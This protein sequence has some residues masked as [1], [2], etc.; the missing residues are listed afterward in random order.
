MK[1]EKFT[2]LTVGYYKLVDKEGWL[3]NDSRN[4]DLYER[5][6][7][8][9]MV[10]IEEVVDDWCWYEGRVGSDGDDYIIWADE[11]MYFEKV[12]TEPRVRSN[13]VDATYSPSVRI[14]GGEHFL[15]LLSVANLFNESK[16]YFVQHTSKSIPD[17][18]TLLSGEEVRSSDFHSKEVTYEVARVVQE[19]I[20]KHESVKGY[21]LVPFS[22]IVG[23]CMAQGVDL[24]REG[25]VEY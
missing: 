3:A 10:F 4:K 5:C 12:V 11:Y 6:I 18:N 8:G 22:F 13:E 19:A 15:P 25:L 17:G 24:Y 7:E 23:H 14:G 21:H 16:F 20:E 9:D 2:E 1:T